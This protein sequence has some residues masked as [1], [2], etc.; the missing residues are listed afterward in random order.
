MHVA[1]TFCVYTISRHYLIINSLY[2][3]PY[4]L[5]CLKPEGSALLQTPLSHL[6]LGHTVSL[7][8]CKNVC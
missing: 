1:K 4:L 2:L 7:T 5:Q 3:E 8:R 6:S